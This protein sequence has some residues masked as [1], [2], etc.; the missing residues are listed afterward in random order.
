MVDQKRCLIV[1]G[2]IVSLLRC[3][4]GEPIYKKQHSVQ[5]NI[6][7]K[8]GKLTVKNWQSR[9]NTKV[10][11]DIQERFSSTFA[12]K[13]QASKEALLSRQLDSSELEQN[14][15]M[16]LDALPTVLHH[17]AGIAVSTEDEDRSIVIK[18]WD[19]MNGREFCIEVNELGGYDLTVRYPEAS[20]T[21]TQLPLDFLLLKLL[22]FDYKPKNFRDFMG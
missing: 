2:L 14:F 11:S 16:L 9:S 4:I 13:R 17:C 15:E 18:L 7:S 22:A 5:S 20:W 1:Y 12:L 8:Q 19:F 3:E 6:R 10:G 21:E